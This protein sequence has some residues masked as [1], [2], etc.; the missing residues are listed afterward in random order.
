M[1]E[2]LK[3]LRIKIIA[4]IMVV[5][6]VILSIVFTTIVALNYYHETDEIYQALTLALKHDSLAPERPPFEQDAPSPNREP[7]QEIPRFEIGGKSPDQPFIPVA[8]YEIKNEQLYLLSDLASGMIADNAI[9]D[10]T[11][12]ASQIPDGKGF[13][14]SLGVY[15]LKET[16]G[17]ISLI[18]FADEQSVSGWKSLAHAFIVVGIG[19]L[20]VFFVMSFLISKWIVRPVRASWEQQQTF[21]ADA[22]HELKTPLTVIAADVAILK[23]HPEKSITSQS[24]WVES[25]EAESQH[26]HELVSDL[27]LLM[28]LDTHNHAG[29]HTDNRTHN[30]NTTTIDLSK[31]VNAQT[32][33]FEPLAYEQNI[34]FTTHI[35]DGLFLK[36]NLSQL[37]KLISILFDNA[38]KYVNEDGSIFVSLTKNN[39]TAQFSI[40]NTGPI[41]PNEELPHLFDRFYRSDKA[42]TRSGQASFGLGLSI[43]YEIAQAHH[44]TITATSSQ[45][46]TMFMVT[47]PLA[48]T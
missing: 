21:I 6:T 25:I 37:Q 4:L 46:G 17:S 1:N 35:D 43:A 45:D 42:R 22:S 26:M 41:I 31:L 23:R 32:L 36:G 8:V 13:L 38:F 33:Q 34:T 5:V 11:A 29:H 16:H 30:Q 44:G 47:L 7:Q 10:A 2:A 18:A 27:L 12:Q 24:Q 3:H 9:T 40:R 48:T 28:Q 20:A 39:N 14:D 19:A 15:Y